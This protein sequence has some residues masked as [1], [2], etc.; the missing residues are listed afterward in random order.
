MFGTFRITFFEYGNKMV[1]CG[2][3]S[4]AKE[5]NDEVRDI[6]DKVKPHVEAKLGRELG[7]FNPKSFKSQVVAG[8]NYFVKVCTDHAAGEHIHVRI[9]RDLKGD[10]SLHSVQE[11]KGHEDP[12]EYF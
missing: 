10:V 6:C 3:A 1:L 4:D 12:I 8:M 9:Y 2:G 5:I 7:H 11:G